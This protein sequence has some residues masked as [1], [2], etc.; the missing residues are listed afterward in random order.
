M[1]V[2]LVDFKRVV[3]A[4][5]YAYGFDSHPDRRQFNMNIRCNKSGALCKSSKH[6]LCVSPHEARTAAG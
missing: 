5:G 3:V 4:H 2:K 1:Q 6:L